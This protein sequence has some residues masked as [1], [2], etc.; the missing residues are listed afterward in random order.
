MIGYIN[1]KQKGRKGIGLLI[2]SVSRLAF[3]QTFRLKLVK[4]LLVSFP[5]IRAIFAQAVNLHRDVAVPEY[6]GAVA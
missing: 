2:L 3:N 1:V 4:F 5:E 6:N